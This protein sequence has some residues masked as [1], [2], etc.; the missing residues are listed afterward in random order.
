MTVDFQLSD[1]DPPLSQARLPEPTTIPRLSAA[2]SSPLSELV[3]SPEPVEISPPTRAC[4]NAKRDGKAP[5]PERKPARPAALKRARAVETGEEARDAG[6]VTRSRSSSQAI[7]RQ[8]AVPRYAP[9]LASAIDPRA[10]FT[11]PQERRGRQRYAR[12]FRSHGTS[13]DLPSR[14]LSGCRRRGRRRVRRSDAARRGCHQ[15]AQEVFSSLDNGLCYACHH[16]RSHASCGSSHRRA[17]AFAAEATPSSRA[18]RA[19]S[20]GE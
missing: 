18:S 15:R 1:A 11:L 6:R 12:P 20:Y 10:D 19:R 17:L 8:A 13:C 2:P 7:S 3:S 5:S 14:T 4:K 9:S 16:T